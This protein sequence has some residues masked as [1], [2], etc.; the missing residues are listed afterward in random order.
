MLVRV[1]DV[2]QAKRKGGESASKGEA[3]R[4]RIGDQKG[5]GEKRPQETLTGKRMPRYFRG[6]GRDGRTLP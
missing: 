1:S 3:P 6:P 5:T 2:S 4:N